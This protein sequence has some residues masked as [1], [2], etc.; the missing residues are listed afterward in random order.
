[1][2][3]SGIYIDHRKN[4]WTLHT[5]LN[6]SISSFCRQTTHYVFWIGLLEPFSRSSRL[7]M[8]FKIDVLKSFAN[9][10]G[11]HLCWSLFWDADSFCLNII[12]FSLPSMICN[13]HWWEFS[14]NSQNRKRW[15]KKPYFQCSYAFFCRL[16]VLLYFKQVLGF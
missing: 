11:K 4:R 14:I 8:F 5:K 10:I 9:F 15:I 13:L 16:F 12:F 2:P 7:Q 6:R 1:M 3:L